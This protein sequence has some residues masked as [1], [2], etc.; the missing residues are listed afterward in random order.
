MT[1]R[2]IR[3]A[4]EWDMKCAQFTILSAIFQKVAVVLNHSAANFSQIRTYPLERDRIHNTISLNGTE[5]K[6]LCLQVLNGMRV[7]DEHAHNDFLQKLSQE[8]R[9]LRWLACTL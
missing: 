4:E 2:L 8:G 1:H 9:L 5:A 6:A 7:P 3:H